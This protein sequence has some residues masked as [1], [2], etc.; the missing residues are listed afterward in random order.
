[1]A[2]ARKRN[3]AIERLIAYT[4]TAAGIFLAAVT[5]LV[6]VNV[7]LRG[8]SVGLGDFLNWITGRKDMKFVLT[9]PEWYHLSCLA[10][11]VS[12]F[13]GL[14]ATSYRNDHIKV[15]IL[16]DWLGPVG[17]RLL[18]T[19][20]TGILFLV[21]LVFTY[22]LGV[23]V[24]SGYWSG[25]ATYDLRLKLWPFHL[26]MG[27]GILFATVLVFVRLLRLVRGEN[28]EREHKIEHLE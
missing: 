25:E 12:V 26:V 14:A 20:A 16:W 11:G 9:I 8:S 24:M 13:W 4:E 21:L 27:I 10:L 6:F 2:Q 3:S 18:D 28:V 17:K 5:L 22:M 1:M 19:F 23:K 15:D 7:M